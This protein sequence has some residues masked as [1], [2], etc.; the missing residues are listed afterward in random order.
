MAFWAN[1]TTEGNKTFSVK[2]EK[3]VDCGMSESSFL[4]LFAHCETFG[5]LFSEN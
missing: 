5:I 3:N 1:E 4:L 2:P